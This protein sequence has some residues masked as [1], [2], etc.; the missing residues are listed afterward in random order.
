[1]SLTQEKLSIAREALTK[2]VEELQATVKHHI[3]VQKQ[4]EEDARFDKKTI[5]G[6]TRSKD[7]R[8]KPAKCSAVE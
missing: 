5:Q 8:H 7:L 6:L 4:L 2:I 3:A 1:M